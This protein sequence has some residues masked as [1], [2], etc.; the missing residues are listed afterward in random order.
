MTW[1]WC[2]RSWASGVCAPVSPRCIDRRLV[3]PQALRRYLARGPT[4]SDRRSRLPEPRQSA[5]PTCSQA[6]AAGWIRSWTMAP[7]DIR[8]FRCSPPTFA[9]WSSSLAAGLE[10]RERQA[11]LRAVDRPAARLLPDAGR[12]AARRKVRRHRLQRRRLL[13]QRRVETAPEHGRRS[14]RPRSPK[15]CARSGA[16]STSSCRAASGASSPWRC[17]QYQPDAR[18]RA[19]LDFSGV[20]ERAVQ[21]LKDMDEFAQ[22]RFRL[23]VAVPSRARRRVPGH[24]PR[25]MGARRAA[26]AGAGARG[27]ARRP[28]PSRRRSSSSATESSRSTASA[29]RTSPCSTRPAAFV[30]GAAAGWR[31][32]AR[33]HASASAP[34]P[35]LLAFVND[36]FEAID[37]APER[38]RC[39]PVRRRRSVSRS[40]S[41]DARRATDVSGPPIGI[42]RRRRRD[43]GGRS[44]RRRDRANAGGGDRA[45]SHDWRAPCRAAGRHRDSVPIARQPPRV[46]KGARTPRRLDLRLQGPRV[47]RR[48][49]SAGRGGAPAISGRSAVESA[50]GGVPALAPRPAVGSRRRA[51]WR[52]A[53]PT[54]IV[55]RGAA[56]RGRRSRRRGSPG[57]RARA[58]RRPALAVVGGPSDADRAPDARCWRKRRTRSRRAARAGARRART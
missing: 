6:S 46:R 1:H 51:C 23:E 45:R 3:A 24:Q 26:G 16:T 38:R 32:A 14:C 11:A 17:A 7:S 39:V 22:S 56:G 31:F 15:R 48:G 8:S 34:C 40:E 12:A 49:R 57:A 37:K 58:Q 29:T 21:L 27:S 4:R 10:P 41:A 43:R 13:E 42:H 55:E 47:F 53:W 5:S 54:A 28:T 9:A 50:R 18:A 36:V 20:L 33:D 2:S 35:A 52:R 19:L 30:D 44:R 25:A